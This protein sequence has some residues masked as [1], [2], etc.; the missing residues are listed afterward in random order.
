MQSGGLVL[1]PGV[2]R[3][4]AKSLALLLLFALH[5]LRDCLAHEPV[6]R[7]M[8]STDAGQRY[9]KLPINSAGVWQIEDQVIVKVIDTPFLHPCQLRMLQCQRQAYSRLSEQ[10]VETGLG[11]AQKPISNGFQPFRLDSDSAQ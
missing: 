9:I 4:L 3:A 8:A 10:V 11:L 6:R 2:E 1:F 5:I 7:A